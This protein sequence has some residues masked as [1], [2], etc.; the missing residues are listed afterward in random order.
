MAR[1][2]QSATGLPG[3]IA[4]PHCR[5]EHVTDA[6]AGVRPARSE[7]RLRRPGRP[8]RPGLP[9]RRARGRGRR[10]H[11]A[12]LQPRPRAGPPEFVG[13]L[14]AAPAPAEI[15]ALVDERRS[16]RP[17]RHPPLHRR[18]TWPTPRPRDRPAPTPR[19]PDPAGKT[20]VAVTACPT[21]IAHTYMAADSLAPPASGPASPCSVETQGSSGGSTPLDAGRHRRRRRGHLRHRRRRQGPR[22]LR[23]QARD[24]VGRQARHQ[25]ARHDGRRGN[26]APPTT[27]TPRRSPAIAAAPPSCRRSA[28]DVGWGTR[29]RQILLTGVSYMIPFVAAGGLLIA[30][31][32]LFARLRDR[33][34]RRRTIVARS[35]SQP[36]RSNLPDGGLLPPTSARVVPARRAGVRLPGARAG[37]LHRLRHRRPTRSRARLHRRRGRA[38]RRRRLHRRS[39][40]R[41]ARRLRRTVDRRIAVP[42][43]GPRPDA[44]G[45]HP[46]V[47]HADRRHADVHGA[48]QAAGRDHHRADQLAEQP[49]RQ[50][51]RS[52]SA[53]SSA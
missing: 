24:R 29:L 31:G 44:G 51:G 10:A 16:T 26:R 32:F 14:R 25:R 50:L 45:G 48:R 28:G 52:C 23:R 19:R 40:R 21:G 4:I 15:V 18:S 37:R 47:R 39:R 27:R 36:V 2:S 22:A 11:E 46:A 53:S 41:S 7:G 30:L 33:R 20:I 34:Q 8:R 6:V 12:A 17:R 13:A 42:Q 38:V 9:D 3:G 35:N 43:L 1:E 5:S 49:D